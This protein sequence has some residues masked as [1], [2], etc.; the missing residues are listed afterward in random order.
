MTARKSICR[1]TF[2]IDHKELQSIVKV[3][4]V[5]KHQAYR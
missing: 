4:P 2:S 3:V 1:E 5:S